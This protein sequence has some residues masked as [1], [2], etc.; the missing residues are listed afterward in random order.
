MSTLP[1]AD[2]QSPPRAGRLA[3]AALLLSATFVLS[4]LLGLIRTVVM[5]AVF[6]IHG[7]IEAYFTAFRIPDTV[8][9]LVSGG[10]LSSAFIPVFSGL[11]DHDEDEAWRVASTVFNAMCVALAGLAL[12]AFL[13]AAPIMDVIAGGFRP[14]QLDLTVH[15]TRIMLLQPI[16][17]GASAV[18][19]A[20]LQSYHRFLLTALAPLIYNVAIII[21]ALLGHIYGV[22]GL[23][24]AVVIGA[25][26]QFAVQLPGIWSDLR[27][28]YRGVI[29]RDLPA[30]RQILRLFGPRVVGLAAFQA[31]LLITYYLATR[32]PKGSLGAINYSWV[33]VLFPVG[34]LGTAAGTAIF[35]SLSRLSAS[36]DIA[37]IRSTVNRSLRLVLF[38]ALP[39]AIGL[40]VLRRP[41]IN[42]L[43]FHG[44][45]TAHAT[46]QT[47]FALLFYSLALAPLAAIEVLPRV[48]YAVQDTRTPVRIAV[49]A[50]ALDAVL[51]VLFVHLFPRASGQGGLALATAIA[52]TV[53]AVWLA[54]SLEHRLEGIGRRSLLGA[55]RDAA[56]AGIAMAV[57]LY[58]LLDP[59]SSIFAQRGLGALVTVVVEVAV[60]AGMFLWVAY[61]LGAPELYEVRD[62]IDRR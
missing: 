41:V 55:L 36:E 43:L 5:G 49:V 29:E 14:G 53:Q 26:G 60:G 47:A 1:A 31:M 42:L 7:P 13:F 6:G 40:L 27:R 21:G 4:R 58:V 2:V 59:L 37:G 18:V 45:W 54:G 16:F 44:V 10:A 17:L 50:V 35:P 57:V 48:F 51:S 62:L 56:L 24:W 39:A 11:I 8:F 19:A 12:L 33:L 9:I 25:I 52:T 23:A 22:Q 61:L 34:A 28:R 32:L 46:E 15:L 20:M 3:S 30:V 38:L